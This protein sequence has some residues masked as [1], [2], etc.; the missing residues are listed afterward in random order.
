VD[1]NRSDY[2]EAEKGAIKLMAQRRP[3]NAFPDNDR[4]VVAANH[5]RGV[6]VFACEIAR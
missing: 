3:G 1:P 6:A 4:A 5:R 2:T